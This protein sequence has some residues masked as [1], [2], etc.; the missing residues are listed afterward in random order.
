MYVIYF[1]L[2]NPEISVVLAENQRSSTTNERRTVIVEEVIIHPDNFN[3]G[4]VNDIALLRLACPIARWTDAV[5]PVCLPTLPQEQL[6]GRTAVVAGWGS[7][8]IFGEYFTCIYTLII[9]TFPL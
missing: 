7:T 9:M 4:F 6:V 5:Q 3:P 1:S 8:D 2:A